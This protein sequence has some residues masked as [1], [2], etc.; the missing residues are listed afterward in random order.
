MLKSISFLAS[1]VAVFLAVHAEGPPAGH[2]GGFGEPTCSVCH[3]DAPV[4]DGAGELTLAGIP[5]V[6][7]AG[8]TY[9]ISVELRHELMR[10]SGF[11]LS[12]RLTNGKQAGAFFPAN[13]SSTIA[14]SGGVQYLQHSKYRR[15]S[16]SD[17]SSRW[18]AKWRAPVNSADTIIFNLA[19]N[20]SNDDNSPLGDYVYTLEVHTA[21][22][23]GVMQE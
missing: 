11:Q 6:A 20:A 5:P 14:D 8:S 10:R 1:L 15:S 2:T 7:Q 23:S 16:D 22:K 13:I 3:F 9:D 18:T 17:G 21:F 19:A 12:A 4:N